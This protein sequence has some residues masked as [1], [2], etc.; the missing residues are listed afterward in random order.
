MMQRRIVCPKHP[1]VSEFR[2][3]L[4]LFFVRFILCSGVIHL[5]ERNKYDAVFDFLIIVFPK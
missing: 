4:F 2:G 5:L 1:L 3:V